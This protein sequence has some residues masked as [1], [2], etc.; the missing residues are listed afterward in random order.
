MGIIMAALTTDSRAQDELAEKIASLTP[1][2][3]ECLRKVAVPMRTHEIAHELGL[4]PSTVDTYISSAFKKL[5]VGDRGT[6]AR[7]LVSFERLS[8]KT[9]SDFPGIDAPPSPALSSPWSRLPLPW[10][11]RGRPNNDL[12]SVQL[13]I[14]IL[15]ATT[16]LLGIATLYIAA[17]AALGASV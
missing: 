6:A 13:L 2:E 15:I 9:R 11:R 10:P 7:I 3:A 8:E 1:R 4:S 12:T 16:I 17:L 5:G 14:A